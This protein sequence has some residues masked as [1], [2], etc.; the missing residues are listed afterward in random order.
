MSELNEFEILNVRDPLFG[1][2]GDEG[3]D[4]GPAIQAALDYAKTMATDPA[5]KKKGAIVFFPL[6]CTRSGM[7]IIMPV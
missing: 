2:R 4:D 6:E 7:M 3:G 1:A 5:Q